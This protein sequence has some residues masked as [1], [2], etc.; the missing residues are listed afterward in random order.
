MFAVL[1]NRQIVQIEDLVCVCF[2]I[3]QTFILFEHFS[4]IKKWW[5][6]WQIMAIIICI[7]QKAV[8]FDNLLMFTHSNMQLQ[9]RSC[10]REISQT[11]LHPLLPKSTS[12]GIYLCT[13]VFTYKYNW[14][15]SG[16]TGLDRLSLIIPH[17]YT[18]TLNILS[19]QYIFQLKHTGMYLVKVVQQV[20][21]N[22]KFKLDFQYYSSNTDSITIIS[23]ICCLP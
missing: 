16:V 9:W 23:T 7:P 11:L 6:F 14:Y 15:F 2:W 1:R 17:I 10:K 18:F 22:G 8:A 12:E 4:N 20:D 13:H 19:N 21:R 5:T 3:C